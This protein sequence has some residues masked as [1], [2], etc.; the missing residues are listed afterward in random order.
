M[1]NFDVS[2]FIRLR[3]QFSGQADKASR[4]ANKLK[5]SL[6]RLSAQAKKVG[7]SMVSAGKSLT[8]FATVP[9]AL[10]ARAMINAAS[11]A[12]ETA[13]KFNDVFRELGSSGPDAAARLAEKYKLATSTSQELLSTTGAILSAS[14]MQTAQILKMSEAINGA[15]IDLA[16][17]HNFQGTAAES[18]L[19]LTKALLGEAESLKTNF[20]ITIQQNGAFQKAVKARMAATG[21][22]QSAAKAEVIYASII[23][24]VNRQ[25]AADNFNK[26]LGSYANQQRV[27]AEATKKL[28]E[29]LG[30]FLLPTM[31]KV[32]MKVT[33][34]LNKLNGLSDSNKKLIL[35]VAAV[36]AVLGP[37]ALVVG[38][39]AFAVS[40]LAAAFALLTWP[41][42][43]IIA[44]V[45]L[46][47]VAVFK[48]WQN[49]DKLVAKMTVLWQDF[50]AF[51]STAMDS[52]GE[53]FTNLGNFAIVSLKK[54]YNGI[55]DFL[56]T[57]IKLVAQGL[58]ALGF[59]GLE[60][61]LIE[62]EKKI[63]FD[64]GNKKLGIDANSSTKSQADVNIN[65]NAPKGVVASTT[66][67]KKGS[68]MNLGLSMGASL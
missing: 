27:A 6:S 18:S 57:P 37:L 8:L 10:A 35:I 60:S 45:G 15:S 52:I 17:F 26:T 7:S 9:I 51:M 40:G 30:V 25:K 46:L 65:L 41:I 38:S 68:P 4:A 44:A 39:V 61:K 50:S 19:I 20:G 49:W 64:V 22:T 14:G 11:D 59:E 1:A 13:D 66:A 16:S 43:L 12:Q 21:A 23:K 28:G 62:F 58:A 5:G 2:Y 53:A 47:G 34:F 31:I 42:L 63:T 33:E 36:I 55:I 3:D 24:Q 29:S 48:I 56:L 32:T 54:I 67:V